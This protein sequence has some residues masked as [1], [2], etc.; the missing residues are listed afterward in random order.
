MSSTGKTISY[1]FHEYEQVIDVYNTWSLS[2]DFS[3]IYMKHITHAHGIT[4][5]WYLQYYYNVY[6]WTTADQLLM[7]KNLPK[8]TFLVFNRQ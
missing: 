2:F 8:H 6:C 1:S 7:H 4:T 5:K 3:F